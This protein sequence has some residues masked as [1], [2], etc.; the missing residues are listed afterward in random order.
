MTTASVRKV[1]AA[2]LNYDHP[3]R[4]M[5]DA[6]RVLF[7]R[8]AEC[9]YLQLQRDGW[10]SSAI[11]QRLYELVS[12]GADMVFMQLQETAVLD[13]AII[14]RI[15]QDFPHVLLVHWTGDCRPW[16]SRYL[17]S[18][19][20]ATHLTLVS[21][22]GQLDLFRQ[23]GAAEAH[24]MQIGLD[25]DEDVLGLPEWE[26][27]FRVPDVV[28]C[29]SYYPDQFPDGSAERI[30]TLRALRETG[31]DVGVVGLGWPAD[32]PCV[33]S[34][35][36]KQQHHV[37]KRAKVALSINH[38]NHIDRYYSDRQ[39]IS[40]A[41]G[42]PVVCHYVP[43]MEHEF[44][45]GEHCLWF[46]QPHEAVTLVSHL[47]T[48]PERRARIGGAGR[49]HVME[50]HSWEARLRSIQPLLEQTRGKLLHGCQEKP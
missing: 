4:G 30:G 36:V 15:R 44:T 10:T 5:V 41:S 29:G 1:V 9:D 2:P 39:L 20:D 24:Y 49:A 31:I 3:Q 27:K 35:G 34:C 37:W 11:G 38:F 26:P 25:W 45:N 22:V 43:G 8:V 47:L 13:A 16:V 46:K 40:M 48:D 17:M 28:F 23:A 32:I 33:G 50:Q 21:S 42:T 6:M 18:V 12:D 14:R 19:C 7:D